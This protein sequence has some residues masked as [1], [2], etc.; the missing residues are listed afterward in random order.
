MLDRV[1]GGKGE[2]HQVFLP[3]FSDPIEASEIFYSEEAS[4]R[5]LSHSFAILYLY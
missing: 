1:M 4:T 2:T 3:P 5:K